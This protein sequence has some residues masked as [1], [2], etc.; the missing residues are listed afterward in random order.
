M[1]LIGDDN[2]SSKWVYL[3]ESLRAA[4]SVD[5]PSTYE[6]DEAQTVNGLCPFWYYVWGLG[7]YG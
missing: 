1:S 5:D 4:I 2:A 3:E 7:T 6:D